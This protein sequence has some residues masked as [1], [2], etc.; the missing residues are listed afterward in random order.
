M[1]PSSSAGGFVGTEVEWAAVAF[2][3]SIPC[4]DS[5]CAGSEF[6]RAKF[7]AAQVLVPKSKKALAKEV[8]PSATS[9]STKGT[10]LLGSGKKDRQTAWARGTR[11]RMWDSIDPGKDIKR[12]ARPST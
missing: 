8:I 5:I 12:P 3:R 1:S 11:H 2:P 10:S 9:T 6:S 7:T 4:I